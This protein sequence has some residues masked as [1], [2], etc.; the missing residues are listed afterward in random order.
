MTEQEFNKRW[1]D[2]KVDLLSEEQLRAF[3]QD[4]FALYETTGFLEVFDS[5]Y[6]DE[7]EH[8]GMPFKVVRRAG[9]HECDLE[10]MPIWLIEFQNGDNA[11]CY[12]EEITK[13]ENAK[14]R[15]K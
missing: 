11:Y 8:N 10:A 1:K 3:K 4:C 7:G 12:P 13:L 5:P 9:E 14:R 15:A 6:D 2:V